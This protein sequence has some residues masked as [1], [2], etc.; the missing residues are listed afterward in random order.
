MPEGSHLSH[1]GNWAHG[2]S[3]NYSFPYSHTGSLL[4]FFKEY[5]SKRTAWQGGKNDFTVD[6]PDQHTQ[7]NINYGK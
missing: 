4:G 2:C 1:L 3:A 6:K 5:T 7:V